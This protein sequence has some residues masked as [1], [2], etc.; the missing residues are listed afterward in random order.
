MS[1]R[2]KKL[3]GEELIAQVRQ[4]H[5]LGRWKILVRQTKNH[6]DQRPLDE[7]WVDSLVERI[8]NPEIL[9]RALHPIHVILEDDSHAQRLCSLAE[10]NGGVVELP[11]DLSVLVFSGQHRLAM[12][13]Q[14]ELETP[15]TRWW[16]GD[17]YRNRKHN[18]NLVVADAEMHSR[19]AAGSSRRVLDH[20]A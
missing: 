14:L 17:V 8:G 4:T 15:E 7:E 20:D 16:H 11:S 12:L 19:A 18:F 9:N 2:S 5:F 13:Q 3:S 10:Q 1:T 6:P